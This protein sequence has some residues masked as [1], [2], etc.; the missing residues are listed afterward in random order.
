MSTYPERPVV[1]VGVVVVRPNG[2]GQEVLLIRRGKAPRAGQWSL[3]GGRQELGERL[4]A[5]AA[6]E[7]REETGLT[8]EIAGL[9]DVVDSINHDDNGGLRYHYS[10]I[11][12]LGLWRGGEPVAASDAAAVRWVAPGDLEGYDLWAETRRIIALALERAAGLDRPRANPA[13]PTPRAPSR[14]R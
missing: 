5:A 7:V 12:F 11:D 2:S 3:P 14:S 6:R 1:G 4:S 10:L 8:V 13:A 9:L